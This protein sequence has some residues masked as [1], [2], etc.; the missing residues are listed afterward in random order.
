[1]VHGVMRLDKKKRTTSLYNL[2]HIRVLHRNTVLIA[3]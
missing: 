1:M 2:L 3:A